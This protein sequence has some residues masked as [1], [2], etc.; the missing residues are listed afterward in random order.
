MRGQR[1]IFARPEP[2]TSGCGVIS[3]PGRLCASLRDCSQ[4]RKLSRDQ[5]IRSDDVMK[6]VGSSRRAHGNRRATPDEVCGARKAMCDYR[7]PLKPSTSA[8]FLPLPPSLTME[9]SVSCFSS[10]SLHLG[11]PSSVRAPAL[12]WRLAPICSDPHSSAQKAQTVAAQGPCSQGGRGP[13]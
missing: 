8:L 1:F 3:P 4:E 7:P 13:A 5:V 6:P 2:I 11:P 12:T 9:L 10:A